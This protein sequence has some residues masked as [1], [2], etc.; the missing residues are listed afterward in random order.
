MQQGTHISLLWYSTAFRFSTLV[1]LIIL[2]KKKN[3]MRRKHGNSGW[4]KTRGLQQH[5]VRKGW[6][7][8]TS[9]I[10]CLPPPIPYS[11]WILF[12]FLLQALWFFFSPICPCCKSLLLQAEGLSYLLLWDTPILAV[13]RVDALHSLPKTLVSTLLLV[14]T[15]RREIQG[16]MY[17]TRL[18]HHING[19]QFPFVLVCRSQAISIKSSLSPHFGSIP[20]PFAP[21]LY[22]YWYMVTVKTSPAFFK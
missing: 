12:C 14:K 3:V 4:N 1:L 16:A 8:S 9:S 5:T 15:P 18:I 7:I 10:C 13:F 2:V 19:I 17:R 20:C 21:M 22:L 6:A 11:P